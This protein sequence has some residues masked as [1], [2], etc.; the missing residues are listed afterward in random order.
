[1]TDSI[2]SDAQLLPCPFC[3][4]APVFPDHDAGDNDFVVVC[5]TCG[6]SSKYSDVQADVISAW[7]IR[8]HTISPEYAAELGRAIDELEEEVYFYYSPLSEE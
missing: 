1:M 5:T 3:G 4:A 6:A 2:N 7:N 8:S